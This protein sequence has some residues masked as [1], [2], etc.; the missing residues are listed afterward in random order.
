MTFSRC[1]SYRKGTRYYDECI[2]MQYVLNKVKNIRGYG[3]LLLTKSSISYSLMKQ[4]A[5][6]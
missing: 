5:Y 2:A 6:P 4:F 3:I 1:C